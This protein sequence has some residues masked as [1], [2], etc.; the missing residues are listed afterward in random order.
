MAIDFSEAFVKGHPYRR[1]SAAT[2]AS[3]QRHL[4]GNGRAFT[5]PPPLTLPTLASERWSY[6]CT[7]CKESELRLWFRPRQQTRKA[8]RKERRSWDTVAPSV[9]SWGN[10][11]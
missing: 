5:P 2:D 11:L 9:A 8:A 6:G 7:H 4:P 3:A 10:G 1:R